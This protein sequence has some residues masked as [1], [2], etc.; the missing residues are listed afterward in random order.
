[1]TSLPIKIKHNG[2]LFI[3]AEDAAALVLTDHTGALIQLPVGKGIALC[4]CGASKRKPF[5][6]ASHKVIGFDGTCAPPPEPPPSAAEP[7]ASV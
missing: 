7:P 4:R 6:D 2:P 3:T 1:M 5:C